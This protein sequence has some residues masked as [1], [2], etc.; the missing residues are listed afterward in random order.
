MK[1]LSGLLYICIALVIITGCFGNKSSISKSEGGSAVDSNSI[2]DKVIAGYQGWFSAHGDGSPFNQW[3]HW[4][5]GGH[6]NTNDGMPSPSNLTF[7]LYPD[8]REYS[9][10]SLFQTGF[11][12]L[13]DGNPAKLFSSDS[14]DVVNKHFSWMQTYGIDGVALQRFGNGLTNSRT[15]QLRDDIAEKVK[16]A[17][18]TYGRIFYV[19]YDISGMNE[20]TFVQEIKNDWTGTMT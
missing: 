15:K 10:S 4:A 8:V 13:G 14:A 3:I 16:H 12:P 6:Y 7:E 20:N 9:Q 1:K 17:A 5:K 18:E 19:M 11:A 2:T